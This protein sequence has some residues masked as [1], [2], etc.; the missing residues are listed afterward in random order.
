M[1]QIRKL[2]NE[3]SVRF[4]FLITWITYFSIYLGRL[5]FTASMSEMIV[6]EGFGKTE[7]GGVA[8]AF[9]LSY[10]LGQIISGVLGDR[11]AQSLLVF[12][13][14]M[15]SVAANLLF[16]LAPNVSIMIFLWFLNGAAQSFIWAP[17]AR[18]IADRTTG[19]QSV[20]IVVLLSTTGPAGMLCAYAFS[21][22]IIRVGGWKPCFWGAAVW[23]LAVAILW[24]V[25]IRSL[26]HYADKYG[27]LEE[28]AIPVSGSS[29]YRNSTRSRLLAV[30]GLGWL[31][32]A[33]LLHGVLKDG[34]ITWIPTYL[35]ETFSIEPF[36]SVTLTTLLPIVN[37]TGVYLANRLNKCLFH[38]EGKTALCF[39][40]VTLVAILFMILFGDFSVYGSILVFA[41]VTSAMT[42]VNT[43]LISLVPIHFQRFGSVSTV[44]GILNATTY[45]GSALASILFGRTAEVFGWGGVRGS[46][47]AIATLGAVCC[48]FSICKWSAFRGDI[49]KD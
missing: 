34:I 15:G 36:I 17:M 42:A 41:V 9:F 26:E 43:T 16:P 1:K 12:S 47:C 14:L 21:V 44:S 31:I 8:A 35:T 13:G 48:V 38:N 45:I 37:L 19:A 30:T 6:N 7:L 23:L 3:H 24:Y 18:L 22:M 4:F 10:G 40:V 5:N 2:P 46:W 29:A 28:A 49:Y 33:A 11:F 32:T 27:R 20:R 39:F 25:G